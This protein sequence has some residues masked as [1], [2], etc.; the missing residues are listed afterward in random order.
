MTP[1]DKIVSHTCDIECYKLFL[2]IGEAWR[3]QVTGHADPCL[4]LVSNG[5]KITE[6]GILGAS[7]SHPQ[8][9]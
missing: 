5:A 1:K 7:L 3:S 8:G 2:A 6:I 9:K 4:C